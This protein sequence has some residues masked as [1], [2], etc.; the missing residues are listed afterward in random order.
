[1]EAD[2]WQR[3]FQSTDLRGPLRTLIIIDSGDTISDSVEKLKLS[4]EFCDIESQGLGDDGGFGD[5]EASSRQ[6][7]EL[8]SE[9]IIDTPNLSGACLIAQSLLTSVTEICRVPKIGI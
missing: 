5:G 2:D 1:M 6:F 4:V 9:T 8:K 7:K 3:N